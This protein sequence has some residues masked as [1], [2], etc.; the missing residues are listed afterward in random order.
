M[1]CGTCVEGFDHHCTF[2]DNCIGYRNH[3]RFL[4]FLL[5]GMI[6][7][8]L[9]VTTSIWTVLRNHEMCY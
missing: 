6:Y 8:G 5:F 4:N 1:T 7:T 3:A 2:T 9:Q